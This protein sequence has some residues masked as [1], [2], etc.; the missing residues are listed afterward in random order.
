MGSWEYVKAIARRYHGI[1]GERVQIDYE[2]FVS[3]FEDAG[4]ELWDNDVVSD[5]P[6]PRLTNVAA[7]QLEEIKAAVTQMVVGSGAGEWGR[8]WQAVADM[9]VARYSA[10]LH[11]LH[12]DE[13]IRSSG[14]AFASYLRTLLRPY[15]GATGRNSTVELERCVLQHVPRLPSPPAPAPSL[16]HTT[17]HAIATET[18]R[19]LMDTLD[20]VVSSLSEPVVA[21][22]PPPA[23]ALGLIDGLVG[24]L[25]WTTWKDCGT[26]PDEEVCF[27]PVWPMG[28]ADNHKTPTC[29]GPEGVGRGYWG[30]REPTDGHRPGYGKPYAGGET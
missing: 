26:C 28:S 17:I 4:L 15:I 19:T 21:A 1:G 30:G 18:C 9:V 29:A 23:E 3:V 10:A 20:M 24:Y 8:N 11:H 14:E 16:A 27:I 13:E 5:T 7:G 22:S 12:T 2:R 25:Q 6:H